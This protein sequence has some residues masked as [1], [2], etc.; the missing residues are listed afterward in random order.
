VTP[1]TPIPGSTANKGVNSTEVPQVGSTETWEIANL[2]EDAH[3]IHIHL[4]QFQL[5]N[6]EGLALD[7][8]NMDTPALYRA[9]YDSAFPGGM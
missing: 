9:T 8:T 3:P 4:I 1:A 6:R 2:T 5:I 7:M